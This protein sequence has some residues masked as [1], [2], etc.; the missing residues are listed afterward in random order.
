MLASIQRN[1]V[2]NP[3]F[4][5][6][7][8]HSFWATDL[9]ADA[10]DPDSAI[11]ATEFVGSSV[12]SDGPPYEAF[13]KILP[14]NPHVKFFDS[15]QRGYVS[16]EVDAQQMLT[17]FRVISDPRDPAATVSALQSFVVEPG[18]AGAIAV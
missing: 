8:I 2:H 17:H 15:R 9:H 4:W 5:G 13:M 6:G 16:V 1:R 12:T 3:V 11:V 7:D 14:L 10:N 18:R